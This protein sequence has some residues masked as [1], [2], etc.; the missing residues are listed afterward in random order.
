M[1]TEVF[2]DLEELRSHIESLINPVF[3]AEPLFEGMEYSSHLLHDRS[4]VLIGI[5]AQQPT[6]CVLTFRVLRTYSRGNRPHFYLSGSIP[7]TGFTGRLSVSHIEDVNDLLGLLREVSRYVKDSYQKSHYVDIDDVFDHVKDMPT[8]PAARRYVNDFLPR[9]DMESLVQGDNLKEAIERLHFMRRILKLFVG[10][11][12]TVLSDP[13]NPC[14][15]YWRGSSL[16]ALSERKARLEDVFGVS[17]DYTHV[18]GWSYAQSAYDGHEVRLNI[19]FDGRNDLW[20]THKRPNSVL[21]KHYGQLEE[22]E[23]MW[24]AERKIRDLASTYIR[25]FRE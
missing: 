17:L 16:E 21:V 25:S 19:P 12:W 4:G 18:E 1:T 13:K 8:T 9:Q 24:T 14:P 5:V 10:V 15:V 3:E 2:R 20:I 7:L 6:Y 23:R 11:N 22:M